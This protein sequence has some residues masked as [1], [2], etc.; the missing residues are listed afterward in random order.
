MSDLCP[1]CGMRV[2]PSDAGR[3]THEKDHE[4]WSASAGISEETAGRN[5]KLLETLISEAFGDRSEQIRAIKRPHQETPRKFP[6]E[7]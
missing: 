2:F 5:R 7:M 1:K 3:A 4:R 6:P